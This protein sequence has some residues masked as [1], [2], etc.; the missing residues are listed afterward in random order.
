MCLASSSSLLSSSK[1]SKP[2][3]ESVSSL[4]SSFHFAY[5][6]CSRQGHSA[7]P[8]PLPPSTTNKV[9]QVEHYGFP[10]SFC[11]A[12][13][14]SLISSCAPPCVPHTGDRHIARDTSAA[15]AKKTTNMRGET[16]RNLKATSLP[17]TLFNGLIDHLFMSLFLSRCAG[18]HFSAL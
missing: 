12:C 5:P 7:S 18:L 6:S 13:S 17:Q 8:H 16:G 4:R 1:R 3:R 15:L 9:S 11:T 14:A 2:W 10:S